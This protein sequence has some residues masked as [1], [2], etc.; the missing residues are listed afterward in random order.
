MI[1]IE[2][3]YY[4]KLGYNF[5]VLFN[6]HTSIFHRFL[7]DISSKIHEELISIM[8]NKDHQYYKEAPSTRMVTIRISNISRQHEITIGEGHQ[9]SRKEESMG[10]R[11]GK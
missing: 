5:E 7:Q 9:G 4:E 11:R 10:K 2:E 8:Q 3:F 6:D 1:K